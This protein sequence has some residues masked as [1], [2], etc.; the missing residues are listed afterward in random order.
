MHIIE[1]FN[2]GLYDSIIA[3]DEKLDSENGKVKE[4]GKQKKRKDKE[5]N[6][7]RG[8]DFKNVSNVINFDFP[9]DT[10]SYIHRVGRLV[11]LLSLFFRI[12]IFYSSK[13][14][15]VVIYKVL[16]YRLSILMRMKYLD[17]L[18]LIYRQKMKMER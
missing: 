4:E 7:S 10:K 9:I 3:S 13:E 8:I 14:L 11:F 16:R 17:K 18:K 12:L 6:I 15:L 5:Y 2:A 1:Q